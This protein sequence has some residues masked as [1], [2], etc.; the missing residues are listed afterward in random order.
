MRRL[1]IE[2]VSH[3][4]FYFGLNMAGE[5]SIGERVE[6]I[7][8]SVADGVGIEFVHCE[9]AGTKRNPTVRLIIDK[10]G[11]VTLEDCA[12]VSRDVET[13]LDKDD[14]IPTAYV[15]EVSS[16]GIER[17]LYKLADFLR[18]IGENARIKTKRAIG[19]QKNFSGRIA[20]VNGSDI[21]FDDRTTGRV[22]VPWDTVLKANLMVDLS[23]DFKKG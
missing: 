5:G 9:I 13:V 22:T 11:G 6:Q 4:L 8:A 23:G 20:A 7:A 19:G 3:P 21:D 10:P 1:R 17:E 15:L 16:P 2:W 14:F 18:F 12:Q